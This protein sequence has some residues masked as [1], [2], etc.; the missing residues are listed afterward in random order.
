MSASSTIVNVKASS[1]PNLVAGALTRIEGP[2]VVQATGPPAVNQALKS[3]AVATRYMKDI[4]RQLEIRARIEGDVRQSGR[5]AFSLRRIASA[6]REPTATDLTASDKTDFFKLAGAIA[7]RLRDGQDVRVTVK[8]AVPILVAVKAIVTAEAYLVDNG[9]GPSLCATACM[10][11][12]TE[13][14]RTSTYVHLA[15]SKMSAPEVVVATPADGGLDDTIE[16]E[17]G[18]DAAPAQ[19][20]DV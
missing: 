17:H 16:P 13:N 12:L 18:A 2:I 20:D 4:D 1:R 8:G 19:R 7:Q 6:P 15:V 5:V 3:I 11:E 9:S 14:E 10:C